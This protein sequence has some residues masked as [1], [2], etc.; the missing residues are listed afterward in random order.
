MVLGQLNGLSV[1][2]T[3]PRDQAE[4]AAAYIVEQG[5]SPLI[6]PTLEIQPIEPA[7]GWAQMLESFKNA[8]IAVFTS[9][10]AVRHVMSQGFDIERRGAIAAIG[11]ATHAALAEY[12]IT[13]DW[14]PMKDY[15]SEGLLDLPIFQDIVGKKII[16]FAGEGGREYLQEVLAERGAAVEKIAVYRRVCPDTDTVAL[17]QFF[18]RKGAKVVLTT[19]VESLTNL[20]TLSAGV[21][22]LHELPLLVISERM[23]AV[24]KER[25]FKKIMVA[26]N[27]SSE[28]I[29]NALTSCR[30]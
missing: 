6:F 12:R 20:Q 9:A 7:G 17:E 26:E 1:L 15:R 16:L 14:L 24:A 23:A 27:A 22:D 3:R 29:V 28:A 10:N 18:A 13:C 25:G 2:I 30:S 21:G 8:D 4:S 11:T 19:S 5:G